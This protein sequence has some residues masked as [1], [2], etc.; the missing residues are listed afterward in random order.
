MMRKGKQQPRSSDPS[1]LPIAK[2]EKGDVPI[3]THPHPLP[4]LLSVWA[5]VVDCLCLELEN[6]GGAL[7]FCPRKDK[8]N[9]EYRSEALL[10]MGW[11]QRT[12]LITTWWTSAKWFAKTEVHLY[13]AICGWRSNVIPHAPQISKYHTRSN[14]RHQSASG[15]RRRIASLAMKLLLKDYR[16]WE[17]LRCKICTSNSKS[18]RWKICTIKDSITKI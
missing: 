5:S 17:K 11:R 1:W 10:E 6:G 16:S 9:D 4:F 14:Q 7:S 13:W 2:Q 15:D 3:L 12:T 8:K 18:L